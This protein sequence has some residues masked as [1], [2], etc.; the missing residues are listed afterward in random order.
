MRRSRR[1]ARSRR[2]H[3][4]RH[5]ARPPPMDVHRAGPGAAD[6]TTP[7]P[8]PTRHRVRSRPSRPRWAA[9]ARP[10]RGARSPRRPA[11]PPERRRICGCRGSS[12]RSAPR[13]ATA[14][15][16]S[17]SG[18]ASAPRP[19]PP[20]P[21]RRGYKA[22]SVGRSAGPRRSAA[23]PSARTGRRLTGVVA[24]E[25]AWQRAALPAAS[26]PARW[27]GWRPPWPASPPARRRP[28]GSAPMQ[29]LC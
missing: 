28:A 13:S 17:A 9:C 10:Y 12:P 2:W 25:P 11:L 21:P 7:P 22:R 1:A 27:P 15:H 29:A 6:G 4:P 26:Q 5:P 14:P 16:R 23:N 20:R 19:P 18:R 24:A 8:S 3:R